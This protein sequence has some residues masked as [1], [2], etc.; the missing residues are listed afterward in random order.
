MQCELLNHE[1]HVIQQKLEVSAEDTG[2]V[3]SLWQVPIDL[4]QHG[5]LGF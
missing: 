5:T 3:R 4:S 2:V 1:D